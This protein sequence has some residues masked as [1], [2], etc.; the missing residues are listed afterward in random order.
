MW[1]ST[2]LDESTPQLG[3]R[4]RRSPPPVIIDSYSLLESGEWKE[5]NLVGDRPPLVVGWAIFGFGS[6]VDSTQVCSVWARM[7]QWLA[8]RSLRTLLPL[9]SNSSPP[10]FVSYLCRV[11]TS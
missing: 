7:G 11:G 6:S 9:E 1:S 10:H 5:D 8:L 4:L 3:G 2:L